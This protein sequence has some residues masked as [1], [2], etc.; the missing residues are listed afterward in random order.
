MIIFT[1]A[2]GDETAYP[3]QKE[4]HGMFTYFL[5]KKIRESKGNI[6]WGELSDYVSSEV[7]RCSFIENNKMQTPTINASKTFGNNWRN[8][9]FN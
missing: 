4:G 7:K 5:L 9:T 6:R 8:E 3:Y 2:Q 1:A